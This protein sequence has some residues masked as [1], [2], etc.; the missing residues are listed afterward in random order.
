MGV[1]FVLK[2]FGFLLVTGEILLTVN[3][4]SDKTFVLTAT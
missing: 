4:Y 1:N 2:Y 3:K